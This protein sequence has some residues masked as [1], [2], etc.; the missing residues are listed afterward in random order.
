MRDHGLLEAEARVALG[1]MI[2]FRDGVRVSVTNVRVQ[3]LAVPEL[4]T[5]GFAR[6]AVRGRCLLPNKLIQQFD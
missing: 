5:A 4:F 1:A 2:S 3:R 6:Q